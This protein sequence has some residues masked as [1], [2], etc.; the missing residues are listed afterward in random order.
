MEPQV[1]SY[2]WSYGVPIYMALDMGSWWCFWPLISGVMG[3]YLKVVFWVHFAVGKPTCLPFIWEM[4][5]A[6]ITGPLFIAIFSWYKVFQSTWI[7]CKHAKMVCELTTPIWW[8]SPTQLK[9]MRKSNLVNLPR[10][11]ISK[12]YSLR[13]QDYPEISWGWDWIPK[14]HREGFGFLGIGNHH[15]VIVQTLRNCAL[16]LEKKLT[17]A[18]IQTHHLWHTFKSNQIP[19]KHPTARSPGI[20]RMFTMYELFTFRWKM[21]TFNKGQQGEMSG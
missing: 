10:G 1:A 6:Q 8:F 18:D 15:L 2:Q 5:S 19:K 3:H 13:I 17:P 4:Q 14:Y 9:N 11:K 7:C 20:H 21:S 12:T 16:K